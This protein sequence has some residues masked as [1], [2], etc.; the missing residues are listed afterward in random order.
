MCGG[1]DT[2]LKDRTFVEV[3]RH[4]IG[5]LWSAKHF[6][7]VGDEF[8]SAQT[9][10]PKWDDNGDHPSAHTVPAGTTLRIVNFAVE[11]GYLYAE[12]RVVNAV[13]RLLP[14][15]PL[16]PIYVAGVDVPAWKEAR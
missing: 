16:H 5:L 15:D 3:D 2:P 14:R 6:P 1:P 10:W 8:V 12:C 9:Y 11:H 13:G 7:K 4:C